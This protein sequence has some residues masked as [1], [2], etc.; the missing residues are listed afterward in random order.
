MFY[1]GTPNVRPAPDLIP[2]F[3]YQTMKAKSRSPPAMDQGRDVFPFRRN[4]GP[5][6]LSPPAR[7]ILSSIAASI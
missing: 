4:Q 1:L 6:T 2:S 5:I 3:P 7:A